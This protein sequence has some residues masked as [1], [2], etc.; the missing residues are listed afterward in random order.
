MYKKICVIYLRLVK[1]VKK[2]LME[3]KDFHLLEKDKGI[4]LSQVEEKKA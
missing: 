3:V 2:M 4:Y 1:N